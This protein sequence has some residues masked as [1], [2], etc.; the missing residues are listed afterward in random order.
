MSKI[1]TCFLTLFLFSCSSSKH[2]FITGRSNSAITGTEFYKQAATFNWQ[3]RDSFAV[4][5]ILAGNIP[6]FF[7]KFVPVHTE[8]KNS[9]GKSITATFYVS[10]DYLSIGKDDDWVR[11]DIT[12]MAAQE[13]C[14]SLSLFFTYKKNS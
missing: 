8:I 11:I 12:P 9:D 6:S 10:A 2:I 3:Q 13:N 7:K 5:E 1:N 4:R 14:R